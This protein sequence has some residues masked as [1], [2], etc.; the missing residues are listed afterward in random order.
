MRNPLAGKTGTQRK[1]TG[2]KICRT[3]RLNA[4]VTFL[5]VYLYSAEGENKVLK[6]ETYHILSFFTQEPRDDVIYESG[7]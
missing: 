2:D 5:I 1:S 6:S 3:V 4:T 7:A